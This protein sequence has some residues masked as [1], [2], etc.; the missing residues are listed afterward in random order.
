[1]DELLLRRFD[2]RKDVEGRSK[3][4]GWGWM[5]VFMEKSGHDEYLTCEVEWKFHDAMERME[6]M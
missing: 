1:V 5:K 6:R 3:L 2:S 4:V